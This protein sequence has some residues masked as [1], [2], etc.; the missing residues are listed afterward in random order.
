MQRRRARAAA[1]PVRTPGGE[2]VALNCG[3]PAFLMP[4]DQLLRRVVP[5]LLRAA[6]ALAR[7]IGGTS[8]AAL[9][10]TARRAAPRRRKQAAPETNP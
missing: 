10:A 7:E 2:V 1:V 3:G 9:D 5:R 8:G 6:E 4:P